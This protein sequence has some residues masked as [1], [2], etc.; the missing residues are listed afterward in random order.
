M[1][2][3]IT[4]NSNTVDIR[5]NDKGAVPSKG[6]KEK[7]N[8]A[9]S[10]KIETVTFFK[11]DKIRCRGYFSEDTYLYYLLSW[12]AWASSNKTMSFAADADYVASTT[13]DDAANSGQK[14]IPLTDTSNLS[15]GDKCFIKSADS[16]HEFEGVKI[17]SINA[18]VSITAVNDLINSYSSG[19]SFRHVEYW[20]SL[21]CTNKNFK[22]ERT[23]ID[24]TDNDF[25]FYFDFE[26]EELL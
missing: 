14:V 15:V 18:G 4:W 21:R 19:D 7:V 16:L 1:V 25:Y 22:P 26:F 6:R 5:L 20:P 2:A 8:E 10:G 12:W 24:G 11:R 3:R 23:N 17:A 9:F 13:L